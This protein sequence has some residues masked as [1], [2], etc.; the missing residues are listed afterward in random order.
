MTEEKVT[1]AW[2]ITRV[3][4]KSGIAIDVKASGV[5]TAA[6]IEDLYKGMAYGMETF[7]WKTEQD[8]PKPATQ[9]AA[10]SAPAPHPQSIVGNMPVQDTSINTMEIKRVKVE[11][12]PDG[13]IKVS[14][15]ADGHKWPDLYMTQKLDATLKALAQTGYEWTPEF[16]SKVSEYD[17][18]FYA[19]WRNSDKLNSK[20]NPYKNIVAFR[21]LTAT[22]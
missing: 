3:W 1:G 12:Q 20:G 16:L 19:D 22:A 5:N 8:A 7:G 2:V 18:S 4:S 14:L 15:F 9:P 11:P 6:A 17:M 13:K 21:P 10:P